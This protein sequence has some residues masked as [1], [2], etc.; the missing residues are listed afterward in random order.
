MTIK[1]QNINYKCW[2]NEFKT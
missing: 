2:A 1:I